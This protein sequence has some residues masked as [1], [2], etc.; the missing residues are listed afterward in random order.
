ME[1]YD[2][3][4]VGAGVAGL[5]AAAAAIQAGAKVVLLERSKPEERGGQTRWTEALLRMKSEDEVS[6][7]FY[8][9]FAANAG[10][11]LDPS[12]VQETS[13][14][15]QG[16]SG[17]VKALS[18]ADPDLISTFG[19]AAPETIA[20]LKAFGLRFEALPTYFITATQPRL[21]PVGG[22]LAIVEALSDWLEANGAT[23]LYETT[24]RNLVQDEDGAVVGVRVVG[25]SNRSKTLAAGR[26][27][28]ASGGFEGNPEMLS[29]YVGPTARYVRPVARGGYYNRG[30]GVRMAL[31]IG[32]APAGDYSRFHAQPLDPRSGAPEPILLVFN[33]GILVNTLGER[34]VDEASAK[35]DTTYEAIARTILE[36]PDGL[37]YSI[38]DAGIDDVPNWRKGVRSDQPP[39]QAAT[40]EELADKLG[41][42]RAALAAT[43]RS[44]NLACGPGEFRPL[45]LD[46]L[47]TAEGFSPLKSNW[48]RPI[49]TAPFYA[50]PMICGNCFTFGGLRVNS[51]SQVVNADGFEI[52][53]LYA[54]GEAAGL[55][56]GGYPGATSVLRGAVFGRI[57][58]RHATLS[59]APLTECSAAEVMPK[60]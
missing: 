49:R 56:Y 12:L 54:A 23:F 47:R 35:V 45:E 25:P 31:D 11:H 59:R 33:Y 32:A 17:I 55:Y 43:V 16:W 28:L 21:A 9:H 46:G 4:V 51:D 7:D 22:G 30:E 29:Q 42:D 37:A 6:D 57:A 24:A 13:Q 1:P 3:I 14:D 50:Y 10:H 5:S 39:V 38:F 8:D 53:G 40:T 26:V 60:T 44:Y 15:R 36:Q 27:V 58:G 19:A 18:F 34:F 52:P 48:A 20:W 2:V 41:L